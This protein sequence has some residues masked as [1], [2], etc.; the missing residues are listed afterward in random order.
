[1]SEDDG[2]KEGR[3]II[4]LTPDGHLHPAAGKIKKHEQLPLALTVA[5]GK[6]LKDCLDVIDKHPEQVSRKIVD[7][8][9]E[10][11]RSYVDL[12]GSDEG[13]RSKQITKVGSS[14]AYVPKDEDDRG[15]FS[16]NIRRKK[17]DSV[18]GED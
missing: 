9:N 15:W 18:A 4:W 6:I 10:F 16:R 13:F 11:A 3:G 1:M 5:A 2:K 8:I 14:N 12:S 7:G 17:K